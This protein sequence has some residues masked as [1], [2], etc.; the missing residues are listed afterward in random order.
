MLHPYQ[1]L[2][3]SCFGGG[4]FLEVLGAILGRAFFARWAPPALCRKETFR[5]DSDESRSGTAAVYDPLV[6]RHT[7]PLI[8]ILSEL[9]M[10]LRHLSLAFILK[11]ALTLILLISYQ[12]G[13]SRSILVWRFGYVCILGL[14][15]P[16]YQASLQHRGYDLYTWWTAVTTLLTVRSKHLWSFSRT[17]RT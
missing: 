15:G 4:P 16:G 14:R 8:D 12:C 2:A 6:H 3:K 17:V 10:F 1:I 5:P 7:P 13:G 11:L 9:T